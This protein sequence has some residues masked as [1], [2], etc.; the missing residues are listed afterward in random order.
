MKAQKVVADLRRVDAEVE[1]VAAAVVH[2]H[3]WIVREH[4]LLRDV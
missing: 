3:R 2:E 4:Y 1:I